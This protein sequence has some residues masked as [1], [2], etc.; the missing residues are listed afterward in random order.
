MDPD[1]F[2]TWMKILKRLENSILWL[3]RFP[4][5]GEANLK[6]KAIELVGERVASRLIFTGIFILLIY[7]T[8]CCIKRNSYL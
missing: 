4:E 8:R 5:A 6:K 3:L 7:F 2:E 1:I